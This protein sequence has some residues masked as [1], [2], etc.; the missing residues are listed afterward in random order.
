MDLLRDQQMDHPCGAWPSVGESGV[1]LF[2]LFF[3]ACL[4]VGLVVFR[5][6]GRCRLGAC[7]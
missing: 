6:D 7:W 1:V 5:G 3:F 2:W 4:M